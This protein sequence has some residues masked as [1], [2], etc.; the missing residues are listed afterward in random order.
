MI[1]LHFKWGGVY[2]KS[3]VDTLL[4]GKADSSHTHTSS[5][6]TDFPTIPSNTSQLTNDIGF[7][8]SAIK[9]SNF[10]ND[11]GWCLLHGNLLIQW[12][13][14]SYSPRQF[15]VTFTKPYSS[16]PI[17]IACY[18]DSVSYNTP[19]SVVNGIT[20]TY[21]EVIHSNDGGWRVN[22]IAIGI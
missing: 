5:D 21:F 15:R 6:I 14:D 10:G 22:W 11:E 2:S 19:C 17:V 18:G 8:T 9:D 3:E 16:P 12:G 7:I 4:N 20:R 13:T 1:Y